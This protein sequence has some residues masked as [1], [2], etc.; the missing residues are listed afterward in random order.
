MT[1]SRCCPVCSS[2]STQATLFLAENIDAA[3]VS[4]F[5]FASRKEPEY[6]CHRMVRCRLCDLVY[7]DAPPQIAYLAEAYHSASY[8]SAEEANDA[9]QAYALAIEP[10]LRCLKRRDAA[11]EI[12]A[13]TG[14]F[15][16]HLKL[17]GFVRVV[18]VEPSSA[19]I[20]AA[21]EESRAWIHEGMFN[22]SD[23]QP[24]SFDL[25]CCFMTMEHVYDPRELSEAAIRLLRPGG[26][27]VTVTHNYRSLVNRLLGKRSPIIDIEHLQIF[28]RRSI[29][30]MFVRAGFKGVTVHNF[31]NRYSIRYWLRLSPLPNRLKKMVERLLVA[32][33][34]SG[35]HVAVNVGN[36]M[37]VGFKEVCS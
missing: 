37:A 26:M 8:D 19:A 15:L 23:F 30:E 16:E 31:A 11:L 29:R 12:G 3:K 36:T 1:I 24:E 35:R 27:F 18:G 33:R 9:A 25:I 4:S 34:L 14:V 13:G 17:A 28:S 32:M 20:A 6:M 5:S 10:A 21:Q 7:A 22:E 2:P